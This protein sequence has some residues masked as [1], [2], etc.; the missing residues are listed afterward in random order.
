MN[1]EL[2]TCR[3]LGVDFYTGDAAEAVETISRGGLLVAPSAPGLKDLGVDRAYREALQNADVVITDSAFMV[4]VWKLLERQG[5]RRVSGLRYLRCLLGSSEMR[6]SGNSFWIMASQASGKRN[7]DW[8]AAEGIE[9]PSSHIYYA[10]IY[11][12]NFADPALLERISQ[13]RPRHVVVTVGG[14]TQEPLGLYLKRNLPYR[15]SIHCIGAAIAFLSGDQVWIP[16][17]ADRCYL[18]WLFRC[19]SAPGRYVPRYWS[20]RQL[21]SLIFQYRGELPAPAA[22]E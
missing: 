8:L 9:V 11:G 13:L 2:K 12:G 19:V 17:W 4:V 15:P 10:P 7:L 1:N 5:L 21:F 16:K 6:I 22:D 3:V 14:G 18:G 20:A